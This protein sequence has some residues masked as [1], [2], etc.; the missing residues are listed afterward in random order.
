MFSLFFPAQWMEQFLGGTSLMALDPDD[1]LTRTF[2]RKVL[3]GYS[4]YEVADFLHEVAEELEAQYKKEQNLSNK[5]LEKEASIKEY[6]DREGVLK[7]TILSARKMADKIKEDA[8]KEASHILDDAK[9]KADLIVQDARD[10]LQRVYQD[11]SDLRRMHIQ[12][13]NNLKAV[14]QS[15]MDLLDQDPLHSVL[16][17]E[18]RN[19]SHQESL[20]EK[21]LIDS[22]NRKAQT[23]ASLNDDPKNQ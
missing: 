17:P 19:K 16:P 18:L 9:H 10:S 8:Q 7:D 21:K 5:L 13:K 2:S 23:R 12:L 1:I 14:V 4:T 6:Q 20:I 11:V 15:H 3:G 22:L